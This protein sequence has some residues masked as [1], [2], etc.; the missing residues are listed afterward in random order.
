MLNHTIGKYTIAYLDSRNYTVT[1]ARVPKEG[2][3]KDEPNK[4]VL[5]YYNTV[6]EAVRWVAGQMAGT[7]EG[8]YLD[9]W[10]TEHERVLN[11]FEDAVKE[12]K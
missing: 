5:G 7:S 2:D 8:K 11:Q 12:I 4:A 1:A 3:S 10:L 9:E 6:S